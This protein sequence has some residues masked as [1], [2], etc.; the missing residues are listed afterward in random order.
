MT[1]N[2][3]IIFCENPVEGQVK[4]RLATEIGEDNALTIHLALTRHIADVAKTVLAQRK[5][6]YSD[7]ISNKD[8]FDDGHFEKMIQK[9]EDIGERMYNAAKT[10]FGE[11]ANKVVLIGCDCYDLNAGII[12]EAF[13]AL[14][15]HDFVIGPTK[16]GG[17]Y[18]LGMNDLHQEMFIDKEWEHENVVLDMLISIKKERKT[19]YIL[20]TL[21]EVVSFEDIPDDLKGLLED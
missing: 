17:V 3:L 21:N 7:F 13:N 4:R 12:E 14:D 10:S 5:C 11:W 6:Y 9:G 20:P 16:E 19:H 2:H 8:D 15:H 1:I 18:L